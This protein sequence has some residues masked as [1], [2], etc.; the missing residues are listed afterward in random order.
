MKFLNF[1]KNMLIT[2]LITS[3]YAYW[4]RDN[5]KTLSVI[6]TWLILICVA[7]LIL[8]LLVWIDRELTRINKERN[9]KRGNNND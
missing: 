8:H 6:H 9:K 3:W 5:L 2:V 7:A 4:C 1:A